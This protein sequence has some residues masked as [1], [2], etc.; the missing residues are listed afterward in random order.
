MITVF[1]LEL[2]LAYIL[3]FILKKLL[4]TTNPYAIL[5]ICR[6]VSLATGYSRS[7]TVVGYPVTTD[8]LTKITNQTIELT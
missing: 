3:W 8:Y 6:A 2:I 1:F 7:Y 4:K 5:T